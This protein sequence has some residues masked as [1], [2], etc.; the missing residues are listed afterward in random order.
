MQR[1]SKF[2]KRKTKS[3]SVIWKRAPDVKKRI[4]YLVD[5]LN[6]DWIK[7]TKIHSF[8]SINSSSRAYARVWGL[9][10]IWQQALSL[11]ANYIIEVLAEHFDNLEEKEKDKILLH[12]LVHIPKNFSGSLLPHV[13]RRGKRNFHDKVEDLYAQYVK[14]YK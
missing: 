1:F 7:K 3:G 2:S 10:K 11:N 4:S 12:E 14:L 8:R 6:L 9:S 13:R 5:C